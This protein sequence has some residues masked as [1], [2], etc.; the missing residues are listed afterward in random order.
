MRRSL[1]R[2]ALG[3]FLVLGACGGDD[4]GDDDGT[5]PGVTYYQDVKPLV[6]AKCVG[7]HSADGIAPF[8]LTTYEELVEMAGV[9]LVNVENKT[10]PPWPPNPDCNDYFADRSMSDEQI[11]LFKAWVEGGRLMGD[12]ATAAPPLDTE[13]VRLTRVDKTLAMPV[14]YTPQ[15]TTDNP[16]DYRCFVIPWTETTNKFVT[17]FRAVPGNTRVV[18]HVI[19]FYANP[20]Q[21]AEYQALDDAEAGPGYTTTSSATTGVRSRGR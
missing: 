11:A 7:C 10:M 4:G 3:F 5:D 20:G 12:A 8:P 14:S 6:D 18:H 17:G 19:A 9:A 15:T 13:Q 1:G 2:S 21:V 16:D